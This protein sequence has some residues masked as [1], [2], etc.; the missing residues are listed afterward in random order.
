MESRPSSRVVRKVPGTFLKTLAVP[1]DLYGLLER[2]AVLPWDQRRLDCRCGLLPDRVP[3]H[4]VVALAHGVGRADRRLLV[5]DVVR[6][7]DLLDRHV[8]CL[9]KGGREHRA[10]LLELAAAAVDAREATL[11]VLHLQ[12]IAQVLL[13]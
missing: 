5:T 9:R 6:A 13:H 3:A 11:H 2:R 1:L 4:L 8:Y 12:Q 10:A 7:V